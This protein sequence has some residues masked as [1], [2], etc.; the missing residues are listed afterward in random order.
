MDKVLISMETKERIIR[1]VKR[2]KIFKVKDTKEE[3]DPNVYYI[4]EKQA[5]DVFNKR[6]EE[7]KV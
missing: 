1:L 7:V 5:L 2:G 6:I 4:N 3:E